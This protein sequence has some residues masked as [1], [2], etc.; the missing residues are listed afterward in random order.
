M[1]ELL[2][3]I[4]NLGGMELTLF[5]DSRPCWDICRLGLCPC[6]VSQP[7]SREKAKEAHCV[8]QRLPSAVERLDP[9]EDAG[10]LGSLCVVVVEYGARRGSRSDES[11]EIKQQSEATQR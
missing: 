3:V 2:P 9:N 5:R 1:Y 10:R 6:L 11:G 8:K 4:G 7:F